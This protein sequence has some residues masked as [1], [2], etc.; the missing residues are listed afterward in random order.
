MKTKITLL[1]ISTALLLT[2]CGQ[3]ERSSTE[4]TPSPAATAQEEAQQPQ[5]TSEPAMTVQEPDTAS[6]SAQEPPKKENTRQEESTPQTAAPPEPVE[7][8]THQE[9]IPSK[10]VHAK[11]G[12]VEPE[13]T[14]EPEPTAAPSAPA[15]RQ[16]AID[17]TNAYAVTQY[18]VTTDTSLT[19]NNSAYRFPAAVPVDTS[20]ETLK[21]KVKDMVDFIF[22][23]LMM[24]AGMD[25]LAD[26][27]FR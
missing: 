9:D 27:G 16:A 7:E 10:I 17:A 18:G 5:A 2:A 1:A 25:S 8:S 14:P 22:R 21:A 3:M 26:A 20:Q 6:T 15:D 11:T 24:Q 19:L 4:A 12:Y 23:Q 13:A